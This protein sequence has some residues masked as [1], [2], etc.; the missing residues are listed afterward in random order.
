METKDMVRMANQMAT[1]FNAYGDEEGTKELA[2][3]INSFWEPRM[4]KMFFEYVAQGGKDFAP[5]VMN[6]VAMVRKVKE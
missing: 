3:H 4:R 5:M 1:F 2:T 6:A